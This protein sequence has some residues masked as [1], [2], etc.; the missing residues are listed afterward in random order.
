V[1][2]TLRANGVSAPQYALALNEWHH[3]VVVYQAGTVS[4]Y[5]NGFRLGDRSPDRWAQQRQRAVCWGITMTHPG[6][7]YFA[8]SMDEVGIWARPLSEVEIL[9]LAGRTPAGSP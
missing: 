9:S 2:A 5:K 7:N 6:A 8:G 3:F 4:F 1:R